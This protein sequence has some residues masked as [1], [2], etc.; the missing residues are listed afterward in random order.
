VLASDGSW[1]KAPFLL[2]TGADRTVFSSDI[3]TAPRRL[4]LLTQD[5]LGGIGGEIAAVNIETQIRLTRENNAKVILRRHYAGVTETSAL[6]MSVLGRDVLNLFSVIV[7]WPQQVIGLL[8][9]RHGYT[10]LQQ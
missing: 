8:G 3:V 5:R 10:I 2:D 9:Q 1:V 7:D 6:D 4:P